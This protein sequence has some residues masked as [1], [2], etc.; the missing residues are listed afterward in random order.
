MFLLD[1]N[2]VSE[3]RKVAS[4]KADPNVAAWAAGTNATDLFLSAITI[5]ELEIGI[6]RAERQNAAQ[7]AL[8]RAW[9]TGHV[10]TAFHHRILPVDTAVALMAASRHVPVTRPLRD[11]YIAGTALVHGL[12]VVTRNIADFAPMNVQ[13][14]NPWD[15]AAAPLTSGG[16]S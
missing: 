4:G 5:E 3:L 12:I 13:H 8:L 14:L 7:G 15:R 11:A 2:V 1:T 6:L 9:M 10:L 16:A